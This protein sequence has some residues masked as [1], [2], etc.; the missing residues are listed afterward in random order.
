MVHNLEVVDGLGGKLSTAASRVLVVIAYTVDADCVAAWPQSS[1]TKAPARLGKCARR[2]RRIGWNGLWRE[3]DKTEV[4]SIWNGQLLNSIPID[5]DHRGGLGAVER[6]LCGGDA[7][8][9]L[10][11]CHSKG[12]GQLR[13]SANR[14][15]NRELRGRSEAGSRGLDR[16]GS[17]RKVHKRKSAVRGGYRCPRET[18]RSGHRNLCS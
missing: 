9:L 4:V 14:Y 18:V 8:C 3:S 11:S 2:K 15:R 5:V 13:I 12:D 6:G 17:A 16:I 1:E 7:D 10:G